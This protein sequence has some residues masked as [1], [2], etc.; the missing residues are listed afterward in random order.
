PTPTFDERKMRANS[1]LLAR[2]YDDAVR[3]YQA[4]L[5]SAPADQ[6][7]AVQL[8]LGIAL[9]HDGKDKDATNLLQR[10]YDKAIDFYRELDQRFPESPRAHYAHWKAAWLNLRQN[11]TEEAK[12]E[13][14]EQIAQYPGSPEVP[15]ALYWR[16]RMAEQDH[17]LGKARAYY[18]K[19]TDRF[20]S[21]YYAGLARQRMQEIGAGG[22]PAPDPLLEKIP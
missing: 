7:P 12:K 22:D 4:V 9:H 6:R 11:R 15:A 10:D 3:E 8:D 20:S 18:Q 14:E 1:L 16:A 21:Y 13:I 19:L 5:P 2:H 17:D